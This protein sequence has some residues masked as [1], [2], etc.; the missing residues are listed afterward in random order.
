MGA[1]L[2]GGALTC[3]CRVPLRPPV[4]PQRHDCPQ[5]GRRGGQP[6]SA[7]R[8]PAATATNPPRTATINSGTTTASNQVRESGAGSGAKRRKC[9]RSSPAARA[10]VPSAAPP[11]PRGFMAGCPRPDR[12]SGPGAPLS[13]PAS[14]PRTTLV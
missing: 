11:S 3:A 5:P 12:S 13:A 9:P 6:P 1:E 14:R 2:E 7:A 8:A 4:P 10:F